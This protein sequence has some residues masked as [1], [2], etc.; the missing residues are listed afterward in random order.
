MRFFL[1]FFIYKLK[2]HSIGQVN[3]AH[4]VNILIKLLNFIEVYLLHYTSKKIKLHKE[5][6]IR[7][8]HI[9]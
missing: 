8:A 6:T 4:M 3:L 9:T 5:E 1:Y 2:G 7:L